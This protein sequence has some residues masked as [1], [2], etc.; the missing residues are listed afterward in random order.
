MLADAFRSRVR[1]GLRSEEGE[2]A[3]DEEQRLHHEDHG[4]FA[5]EPN[6]MTGRKGNRHEG[7]AARLAKRKL[8]HSALAGAMSR[9][10]GVVK[11]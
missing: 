5:D 1:A 7:T 11:S 9:S 10:A 4:D 3:G 2:E 8:S 6:A